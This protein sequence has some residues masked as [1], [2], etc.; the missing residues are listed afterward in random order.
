MPLDDKTNYGNAPGDGPLRPGGQSV[1]EITQPEQNLP[2]TPSPSV[3]AQQPALQLVRDIAGGTERVRGKTTQYLP[4]APG[5]SPENYSV[6]LNRSVF[7]N[8]FGKTVDG[9]AGFVFAK[10]PQ[11]GDDVPAPIVAQWENIDNAGT[12][13]DV[14]CRD[15][16]QDALTAGHAGILVDFPATGGTQT[17]A[18][19]RGSLPIRPY[20]VPITKDQIVSWRTSVENGVTILTQLVLEECTYVAD[21]QFGEKEQKRYR[22]FSRVNG[23]VGFQL[24]EITQNNAVVVVGKGTYPT[25]EFIPFSEIVTSGRKSMFVSSPPLLD[26]AYLNVAHYQQWSDYATSI[27]KTCVP[28][29]AL[30]GFNEPEDQGVK[31]PIIVGPN[32]V[33]ISTDP[34]AKAEYVS[35]SGEALGACKQSLDDLKSDMAVL[36][37]AMLAPQKR[38]AETAEAKR[39]D[40]AAADSELGVSARGL[41][42][43]VE[44]ALG[45]HAKYLKLED[46][47]SIQINR[48]FDIRGPDAGLIGAYADLAVKLGVPA[49]FVLEQLQ[50]LGAIPDG[51]DLEKLEKDMLAEQAAKMEEQRLV[52]EEAAASANQP[53]NGGQQ[54]PMQ[55]SA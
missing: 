24:L 22:V 44:R 12:H 39:I 32:T 25:Q 29:L 33:L 42:D 17:A 2:N 54:P 30:F 40:K 41:Q 19:E 16:F 55:K 48:D 3:K 34:N 1:A 23:V 11:L 46:G 52:M 20:W 37:L 28:L 50:R 8:V 6:R 18:D 27:H 51:E 7:F 9:L 13:G 45:F 31:R 47:G 53:M 38:A 35:H 43:G 14:F 15:L 36:G 21:G 26:L 10:D 49:R 4:K 5:E